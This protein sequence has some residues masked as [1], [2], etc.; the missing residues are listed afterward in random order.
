[1]VYKH[2]LK[3]GALLHHTGN[4]RESSIGSAA[5]HAVGGLPSS[6]AR[7][8]VVRWWRALSKPSIFVAYSANESQF[9]ASAMGSAC[10][11]NHTQTKQQ[12][13]TFL[14]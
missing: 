8:V 10:A 14:A 4:I 5:R 2:S 3:H 9:D 12:R 7:L 1:M 6:G 11:K 13:Y